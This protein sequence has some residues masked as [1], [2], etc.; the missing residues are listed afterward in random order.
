MTQTLIY[1]IGARDLG[2]RL[3]SSRPCEL[4]CEET[5]DLSPKFCSCAY[6]EEARQL[7]CP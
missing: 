1:E 2:P 5:D 4:R 7:S 3:A 6:A